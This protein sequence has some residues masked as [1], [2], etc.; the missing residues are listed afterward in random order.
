MASEPVGFGLDQFDRGVVPGMEQVPPA[1]SP[2]ARKIAAG[3]EIVDVDAVR[4]H[5]AAHQDESP[6]LCVADQ[7]G[8]GEGAETS[9]NVCYRPLTVFYHQ[10]PQSARQGRHG[11]AAARQVSRPPLPSCL[12]VF[13]VSGPSL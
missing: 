12:P 1:R 9:G 13:A 3:L 4:G 7:P 6:G 11:L 10:S 8:A 2:A 5:F